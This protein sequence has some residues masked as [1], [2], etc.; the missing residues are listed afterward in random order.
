MI[1]MEGYAN[2]I[3]GVKSS[4]KNWKTI[5]VKLSNAPISIIKDLYTRCLQLF[6]KK[7]EKNYRREK[8]SMQFNRSI[9]FHATTC[10]AKVCC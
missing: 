9:V 6:T 1:Y 8:Y 7:F 3:H 5:I 4:G 2:D 10:Q